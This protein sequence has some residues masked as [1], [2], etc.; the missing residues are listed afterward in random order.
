MERPL[1]YSI[2][3]LVTFIYKK[4]SCIDSNVLS[5]SCRRVESILILEGR[6][7]ISLC[8][9]G[10]KKVYTLFVVVHKCCCCKSARSSCKSKSFELTVGLHKSLYCCCHV[11]DPSF[12]HCARIIVA[13][14]PFHHC[15]QSL[16]V[17]AF[18]FYPLSR[19]ITFYSAKCLPSGSIIGAVRTKSS[20]YSN[21]EG[22]PLLAS[23]GTTP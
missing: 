9:Y 22:I 17:P 4:Q 23:L 3:L 21:S 5:S 8:K 13:C 20:A 1:L 16:Y 12:I 2:V 14:T 7:L 11:V 15:Y 19:R 6:N 18:T 10:F